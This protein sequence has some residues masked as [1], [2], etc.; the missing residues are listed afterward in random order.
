[1]ETKHKIAAKMKTSNFI[2]QFEVTRLITES[3]FLKFCD[4]FDIMPGFDRIRG[5]VFFTKGDKMLS[6]EEIGKL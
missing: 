6:G 2:T 3:E 1:M 5:I 4:A